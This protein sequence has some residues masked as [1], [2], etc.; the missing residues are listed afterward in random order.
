MLTYLSSDG[1]RLSPL[2]TSTSIWPNV[3]APDD[4]WW[5]WWLWSS[6]WN[7]NWQGN[8]KYSEKTYPTATLSITNP[9][10]C[11][12]GSNPGRRNGKPATNHL[13]Y[14]TALQCW[15][16]NQFI[17]LIKKSHSFMPGKKVG[18]IIV[19]YFVALI[20]LPYNI[21]LF[22]FCNQMKWILELMLLQIWDPCGL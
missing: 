4:R 12:L 6:R 11:D 15:L 13:S 2:G 20:S 17:I 21:I 5:W 18:L 3:P 1:V 14:G 16:I 22:C 10:R 7:E 8:P 9:T 19:P